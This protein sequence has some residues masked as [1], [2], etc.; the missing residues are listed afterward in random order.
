MSRNE[1][2][3]PPKLPPEAMTRTE[4]VCGVTSELRTP[5]PQN[6]DYTGF[7]GWF[8][9][10]A[11]VLVLF[12]YGPY[13]LGWDE[14]PTL[15]NIHGTL[16]HLWDSIVPKHPLARC[17]ELGTATEAQINCL[18]QLELWK[19]PRKGVQIRKTNSAILTQ[20][21]TTPEMV[22][23]MVYPWFSDGEE[24]LIS[25]QL[26]RLYTALYAAL[27]DDWTETDH[28]HQ[29]CERA[30]HEWTRNPD[31]LTLSD[32]QIQ[33]YVAHYFEALR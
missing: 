27:P 24:V 33:E 20:H 15:K 14:T 23:A 8:F 28:F 16:S 4:E 29:I 12:C 1:N 21:L 11:G 2:S 25:Q 31:V 3:P 9:I 32:Y 6:R 17:R 18:R 30:W 26:N 10:T 22:K 13:L 19:I 5:P 7:F